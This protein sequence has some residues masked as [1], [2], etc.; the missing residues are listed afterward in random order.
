LTAIYTYAGGD[1][2]A[3]VYAYDANWSKWTSNRITFHVNGPANSNPTAEITVSTATSDKINTSTATSGGS[4]RGGTRAGNVE[5]TPVQVTRGETVNFDIK[6]SDPDTNL[7]EKHYVYID[8]GDSG[9]KNLTIDSGS[10][11]YTI[12][13]V[14]HA[15]AGGK[16]T[17]RVY[18]YDD[19]G[20]WAQMELPIEVAGDP[21]A[22]PTIEVTPPPFIR[23]GVP[24]KFDVN[25]SDVDTFQ[26]SLNVYWDF[27]DGTGTQWPGNETPNPSTD[28]VY[29][30]YSTA[31]SYD[32]RVYVDDQ[33][34]GWVSKQ[35]TV[36]GVDN[37]LPQ[38]ATQ[39][40]LD[41]ANATVNSVCNV[42]NANDYSLL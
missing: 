7:H 41:A 8:F 22:N 5:I 18:I 24:A 19:K 34:G 4:V 17:L 21:N 38:D 3:W 6:V 31:G 10:L 27:G 13:D 20:G 33:H 29:H 39:E 11:P 28:P 12:P 25:I 42:A 35:L 30:T 40:Q 36:T 23:T 26:T 37:S 1:F 14:S 9:G 2:T 32:V 16:F 15:Y